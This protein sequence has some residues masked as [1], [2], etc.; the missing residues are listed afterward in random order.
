M[1]SL[2]VDGVQL[3]TVDAACSCQA[4]PFALPVPPQLGPLGKGRMLVLWL[5]CLRHVV[6]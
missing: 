6:D 4:T 5:L 2:Y 3:G 1:E